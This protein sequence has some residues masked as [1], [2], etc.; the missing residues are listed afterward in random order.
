MR[1][2]RMMPMSSGRWVRRGSEI[3]LLPPSIAG[4]EET[5]AV[6]RGVV[7]T[8]PGRVVPTR[9]PALTQCDFIHKDID[10]AAQYALYQMFREGGV[11]A[12]AA[13]QM[14]SAVRAG[15]LGI[16]Q[17]DQQ[18]PALRAQRLPNPGWWNLVKDYGGGR[19]AACVK[20]PRGSTPLLV[21]RKRIANDRTRLGRELLA[22]FTACGMARQPLP[23]PTGKP[24]TRPA[25]QTIPPG[26]GP[27]PGTPELCV[28]PD[29]LTFDLTENGP[30]Q[31]KIL[32]VGLC[33][34]GGQ[35][36]WTARSDQSPWLTVSP[37]SGWSTGQITR[38]AV[39]VDPSQMRAPFRYAQITFDSPEASNFQ[40]TV[41]IRL[42][43]R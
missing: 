3:I 29:D 19:D 17:E 25:P 40:Q 16:Y 11:S 21:F 37:A 9:L 42:N 28:D 6:F 15:K 32:R 33:S 27:P 1:N 41:G 23:V 7:R 4:E 20:E 10:V 30:A 31:T 2:N 39:T 43:W 18:V 38:V 35:L 24:C 14:L 34:G 12:A 5:E 8:S 26:G 36:T 22:A 13:M